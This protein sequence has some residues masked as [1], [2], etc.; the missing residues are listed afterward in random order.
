MVVSLLAVL[1]LLVSMSPVV[2]AAPTPFNYGHVFAS[3]SGGNVEQWDQV[4]PSKLDTLSDGTGGF[5]TGS[6]TD[7]AG[8]LYVTNF[9]N[10][11]V[12]KYAGPGIPHNILK[13]INPTAD[14]DNSAGNPINPE[15]IVFDKNG[16]FYIGHAGPSGNE[17]IY[18]YDSAG[19]YVTQY[20]VALE[21]P[22]RGS[23]WIDLAAD[24]K[25]M[26]YTSEGRLIKRYDVST[27]TQLA[28]FAT[29][30]GT[31]QPFVAYAF[32]LLPNG[33]LIVADQADI[34]RLNPDGSVNMTY[35]VAGDD[36]WFALNLDPDGTSFWSGSFQ[37]DK[38]YKFDIE[39]GG[40]PIQTIDTGLGGGN[41]YGLSVYGELT[42]GGEQPPEGDVE[43]G[44]DVYPVNKFAML[45]PW[46]ALAAVLVI[47]SIVMTRRRRV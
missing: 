20:D 32:R 11:K 24:Q 25:T 18:K 35:D 39:S 7:A 6:A 30:P 42:Q 17:D 40:A 41:L 47:G 36:G 8:N 14:G 34:K 21:V 27:G 15:S 46:L 9:S 29:L 13:V 22:G 19:N 31:R 43:V 16:N 38:A 5:T 1:A 4:A 45:A 28:D 3:V 37:T 44:G 26:Y 23:D 12:V 10:D 2:M 33:G